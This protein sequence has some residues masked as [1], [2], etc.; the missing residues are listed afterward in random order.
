MTCELARNGRRKLAAV[1]L[2]CRWCAL[3]G[4][5]YRVPLAP[6]TAVRPPHRPENEAY[7]VWKNVELKQTYARARFHL[8]LW[9]WSWTFTV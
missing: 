9:P 5:L 7:W 3:A 2:F 8:T 4:M 6:P 1:R